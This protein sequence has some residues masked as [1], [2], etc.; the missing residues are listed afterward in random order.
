[1]TLVE[2]APARGGGADPTRSFSYLLALRAR[3]ALSLVPG[4]WE[5]VEQAAVGGAPTLAMFPA[6]KP[7]WK[8]SMAMGKAVPGVWLSRRKLLDV[9]VREVEAAEGVEALFGVECLA[10]RAVVRAGEG[11]GRGV[12]E[13]AV[14]DG[15]G[16]VTVLRGSLVV[17]C[18]GA[19][20]VVRR[21]LEGGGGG[22]GEWD[23]WRHTEGEV[24]VEFQSR[25]GFGVDRWENPAT[26][27]RYKTVTLPPRPKFQM[28]KA[29]GGEVV[30]ELESRGGGG[31]GAGTGAANDEI[32]D[33]TVE[34]DDICAFRGDTEGRQ[35]REV[36]NMG[37][38][39]VGK[40]VSA[41][42]TGTIVLRP[43]H[44]LWETRSPEATYQLFERNFPQLVSVRSVIAGDEMK[45]FASTKAS[46]FPSIQRVRS[47]VGHAE[48][49][50]VVFIGDAAHCFPPDLG[51]GVNSA[52]DDV[53]VLCRHLDAA[54]AAG[55]DL[56]HALASFEEE[57]DEDVSALM[58]LQKV[59]APYQYGQSKAGALLWFVNQK[60][61][62]T[63]A[64]L[65][66]AVF[67]QQIFSS[68]NSDQRYSEILMQADATTRRIWILVSIILLPF[69]AYL[70]AR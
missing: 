9:M 5:Q 7:A 65:A 22:E 68:I 51:Q 6:R 58:R 63:L 2:R 60:L 62:L 1:M 34:P 44:G 40:D 8:K 42:R 18:D 14:R 36:F 37:A 4:L 15:D 61:R 54:D 26:C 30:G 11:E 50:G 59:G 10:A 28:K 43:D 16:Q 70:L 20:S 55:K 21:C 45:R 41:G 57:R 17:A 56:A 35:R 66:P 32:V 47:L 24:G 3:R 31:G 29:S 23:G 25:R 13:V 39:P 64:D 19:R 27:L 38:L 33:M 48:G 53:V 69:A 46:K 52:L 49:S 12:V 67:H